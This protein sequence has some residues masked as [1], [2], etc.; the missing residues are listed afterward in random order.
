MSNVPETGRGSEPT[1]DKFP[2]SGK[3]M[4]QKTCKKD[5]WFRNTERRKTRVSL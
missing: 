3:Y 5:K 1:P 4:T 2:S